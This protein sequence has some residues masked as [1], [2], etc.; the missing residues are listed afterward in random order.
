MIHQAM[1]A[2]QRELEEPDDSYNSNLDLRAAFDSR[3]V[4]KCIDTVHRFLGAKYLDTNIIFKNITKNRKEDCS[5]DVEPTNTKDLQQLNW[6]L[7]KCPRIRLASLYLSRGSLFHSQQKYEKATFD[8]QQC[9]GL[10]TDSSINYQIYHK[11]AQSQA[12]SG[13]YSEARENLAMSIKSLEDSALDEKTRNKFRLALIFSFHLF[14]V[15]L[16]FCKI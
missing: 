9:L 14:L 11:L 3:N 16:K 4:S 5:A 1:D 6:K 10:N 13:C 15:S 2:V 7:R 8:F 12:K